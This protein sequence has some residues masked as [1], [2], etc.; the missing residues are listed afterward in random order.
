MRQSLGHQVR[1]SRPTQTF[2]NHDV[3][4]T[5]CFHRTPRMHVRKV[6]VPQATAASQGGSLGGLSILTNTRPVDRLRFQSILVFKQFDSDGDGKLTLEEL[7]QYAAYSA[8]RF[9][10][11]AGQFAPLYEKLRT[12]AAMAPAGGVDV[13][14]FIELVREQVKMASNSTGFARSVFNDMELNRL[15]W[16]SALSPAE[17]AAALAIF[18]L[19]DFN[20]DNYVKLEDLRKAQGI[21][22]EV[23]ADKLEDADTNEDGFLS[24][25]D[26]LTSY[27][28]ERPVILNMV[29]LLAHTA[30]FWLILNLPMLDIPVKAVL[31]LGVL[32]KPQF[33]TASVIKIY[34]IFRTVV[35]RARAEIEMAGDRGRGAAA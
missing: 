28:R 33:V 24:F 13:E 32:L 12:E 2:Y 31:C 8:E 11:A 6:P 35:D 1:T 19:L 29:V 14:L 5:A 30:I 7:D 17:V 25:K 4:R 34:Q 18:R 15:G 3:W 10:P 20:L 22:R 23:V 16:D 26:F 21:E 9:G 27:A